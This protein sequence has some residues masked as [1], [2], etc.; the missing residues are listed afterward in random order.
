MIS[1]DP[2]IAAE[3]ARGLGRF[4]MFFQRDRIGAGK[5]DQ[6]EQQTQ[7]ITVVVRLPAG[8]LEDL[9]DVLQRGLH[10]GH[11]VRDQ[12][13][14][15]RRPTDHDHLER[16]RLQDDAHLPAG[17]HIAAKDHHENDGNAN[18][19]EHRNPCVADG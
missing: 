2:G 17:Q 18:E 3:D 6:L 14:P 12:E 11:V 5:A 1:L 13:R 7:K 4:D 10:G 8:P 9:A 19:T 16:Q 15:N